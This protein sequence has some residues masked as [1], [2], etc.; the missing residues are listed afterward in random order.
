[1][2]DSS[3]IRL[4]CLAFWLFASMGQSAMAEQPNFPAI[5]KPAK[6][7][8]GAEALVASGFAALA[9]K[10]VGLITNH[11][12]RVGA[13]RLI[14]VLARAGTSPG[15]SVA[16]VVPEARL[17][18]DATAPSVK[19]TAILTPE[20]GLGGTIEAGAK[21]RSTRDAATGLP[22]YSLYGATSKPTPE[23]LAGLDVLVFDMQDIGVRYYTYISTMGLA[24]QAAAAANLK[25]V[26]LDR[27]NPLGGEYVAGFKREPGLASFVGLFPIPQV[28]GMTAG[29]LARMIKGDGHLR[30]L[31]N[32]DLE[33]VPLT[34]WQRGMLWP[35]T[36][37]DWVPTS[38]NIPTFETALVYAG[39]GL[40]EQTAASEGRGTA[41]PF[42]LIGHPAIDAAE[43]ARGLNAK[44][45]PGVRFEAARF[46]PKPIASVATNPRFAGVE[47]A[48]LR[49]VVTD[50][51]TLRPV[52]IA[53]HMLAAIDAQVRAGGSIGV[54]ENPDE[55]AKIAGS[56]RL[57]DLLDQGTPAAKIIAAWG[58]EV[59]EFKKKRARYLLY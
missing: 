50:Q 18:H 55:F 38:P 39:T 41:S 15:A 23:M 19:L 34:G 44:R 22:V 9:G 27:P 8:T 6:V 29:E 1:M 16:H 28:H 35:D 33:V 43:A 12:G 54:V 37:L 45:L 11:T 59:A 10:R 24:M 49:V 40:F 31:A 4:I 26:V 47:I 51:R 32:L 46:M 3:I 25:F 53:V 5:A 14:D 13:E 30:G 57:L 17:R 2:R 58:A 56:R 7:T 48:G 52:E 21:V 20:H 42:L 36:G